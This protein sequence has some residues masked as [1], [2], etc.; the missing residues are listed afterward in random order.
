MNGISFGPGAFGA[1]FAAGFL[2][3]VSPCVLP[4]I[5]AF[6][7]F[8]SGVGFDELGTRTRRVVGTT[9]LFVAGFGAMF[10]LLGAG[11]G[12][13]GTAML[14]NRRPLEIA[15]GV[16][17]A[18]AGLLYAGLPMPRALVSEKRAHLRRN[19][20][21][22]ATPLLAGGAFALG[23]TPC[24]SPTLGGILLLAGTGG[25]PEQGALLLAVYSLG[26]GVP[27][28]AAGLVFTRM[29]ALV[30]IVRRNWRAVS[31]ASGALMVGFGL[32][33]AL[34]RLTQITARLS[35]V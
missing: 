32:L 26:L 19:R 5:P 4:L 35:G 29:L 8:V 16:V 6:L 28:L 3:F 24:I 21:G 25:H 33:L 9:A 11:V 7:S 18:V 22:R 23:W 12:W 17:V 31:L 13:F 30:A 27:F 14:V 10:I 20:F 1:A 15:A 2:A 34:G